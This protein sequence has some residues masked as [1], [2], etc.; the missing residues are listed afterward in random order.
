MRDTVIISLIALANYGT[1]AVIE[2]LIRR[3][4]AA[5]SREPTE[6]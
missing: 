5:R 3:D 4:A 6:P 2:T 1:Y